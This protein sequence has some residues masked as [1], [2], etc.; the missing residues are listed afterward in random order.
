MLR[1]TPTVKH[2]VILNVI[3]FLGTYLMGNE[4]LF[5]NLLALFYPLS[6]YFEPWQ[7]ISH[8]FM[9]G[10]FQHLL[11][12]M[13]ALWMFGTAVEHYFGQ[14]KF[15]VFYIS[16][17]LGAVALT[18]LV[19]YIQIYPNNRIRRAWIYFRI[20]KRNFSFKYSAKQYV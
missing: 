17:G 20:Y 11:F 5:F 9:H 15:I 12:N 14:K 6:S 7:I 1:I 2:L 16:C 13:F 18:F 10:S 8:M 19:Y 3:I 4:D